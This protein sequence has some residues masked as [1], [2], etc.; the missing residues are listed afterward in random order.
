MTICNLNP[1]DF[2][3]VDN[4]DYLQQKLRDNHIAPNI[5]ATTENAIY[6]VKQARNVLKAV[7]FSQ[8]TTNASLVK[9]L[10][11]SLGIF[12]Y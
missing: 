3:P 2:G 10:G 7:A 1:F 4:M 5:V 12:I 8:V 11:F 6:L 9:S